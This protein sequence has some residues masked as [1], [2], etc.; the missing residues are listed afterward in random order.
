MWFKK[1]AS[2]HTLYITGARLWLSDRAWQI[3]YTG[4]AAMQPVL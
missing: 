2:L 4:T 1:M 3:L